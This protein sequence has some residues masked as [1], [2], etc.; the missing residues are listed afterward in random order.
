MKRNILLTIEYDGTNFS[1]WQ[2]QPEV[3][4][5]QGTLEEALSRVCGT[6]IQIN[7]TSRTD[8]GVHALGQRASF[9]GDFG[10]PT[11]RIKLAVNNMLDGGMNHVSVVRELVSR[12]GY[13]IPVFGMVKDEH[14]KTRTVVSDTDEISIAKDM[15][16]FQFVYKLQEEV[17]R[18]TVDKM[19]AAKL[20]SLKT[21]EL[22]KIKGIGK[23]K[24]KALLMELG[25][26]DGI[27]KADKE[28][29]M[30]VSKISEGDA[31]SIIGFFRDKRKE[32]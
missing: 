17:H 10:I 3:R 8:A 9:A 6:P 2:R 13:E 7:G 23:T 25:S 26:L 16:V 30:K 4:T 18:F 19:K 27:S 28:T 31:E 20:K 1:G 22:E 12:L 5:V 14:H 32:D 11:D 24:A 29:L 21:S 15:L